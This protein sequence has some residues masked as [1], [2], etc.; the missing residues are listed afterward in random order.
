[1]VSGC[2][3]GAEQEEAV[4]RWLLE[5]RTTADCMRAYSSGSTRPAGWERRSQGRRPQSTQ[6][7][8]HVVLNVNGLFCSWE[9]ST[10]T[11]GGQACLE[12]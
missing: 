2:G 1:M 4:I 5:K 6:A 8:R 7:M 11:G 3:A 12:S 9:G 10:K